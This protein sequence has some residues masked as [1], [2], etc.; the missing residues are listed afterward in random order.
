M[1]QGT[2]DER[3][4]YPDRAC[5]TMTGWCGPRLSKTEK[6]KSEGCGTEERAEKQKAFKL[7]AL[8]KP[9]E[10]AITIVGR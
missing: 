9:E 7:T 8:L 4:P 2:V 5:T 6:A 10:P 3:F 1:A